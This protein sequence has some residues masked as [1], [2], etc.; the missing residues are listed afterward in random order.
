MV[1]VV[2]ELECESWGGSGMSDDS[3]VRRVHV[4]EGAYYRDGVCDHPEGAHA[5]VPWEEWERYRIPEGAE[6]C[7]LDVMQSKLSEAASEIERLRE[8]LIGVVT[9]Y[10]SVYGKDESSSDSFVHVDDSIDAARGALAETEE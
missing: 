10:D 3:V 8:V 6:G 2:G 4:T 9:A 5:L 7:L 1:A